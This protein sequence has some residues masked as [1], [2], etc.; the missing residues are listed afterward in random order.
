MGPSVVVGAYPLALL[1]LTTLAL[2]IARLFGQR[3]E[4]SFFLD[5]E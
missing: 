1:M 2:K 5:E 4:E 3:V